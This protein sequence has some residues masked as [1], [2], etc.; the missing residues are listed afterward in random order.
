MTH[1]PM[2]HPHAAKSWEHF[3]KLLHVRL[4]RVLEVTMPRK[5]V[6][7]AVRGWALP[8]CLGRIAVGAHA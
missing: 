2:H 8:H 6:M 5:S 7:I 3:H 1:P 4:N